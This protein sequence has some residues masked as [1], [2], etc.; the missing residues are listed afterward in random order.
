MVYTFQSHLLSHVIYPS[1]FEWFQLKV[2]TLQ[3]EDGRMI[4]AQKYGMSGDAEE[5]IE[6]TPEEEGF[7]A[8]IKVGFTI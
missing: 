2:K 7:A 3:F 5:K 4:Q 1:V 8:N 6:M